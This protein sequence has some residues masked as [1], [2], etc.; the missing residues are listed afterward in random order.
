MTCASSDGSHFPA[1]DD[2][3]FIAL[4]KIHKHKLYALLRCLCIPKM[5]FWVLFLAYAH[6]HRAKRA[7]LS[8]ASYSSRGSTLSQSVVDYAAKRADPSDAGVSSFLMHSN[9]FSSVSLP[10]PEHFL[11]VKF[12][13]PQIVFFSTASS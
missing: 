11:W 10:Y 7:C 12:H 4:P 1:S 5:V 2:P 3:C 6:T 9:S 8:A 13:A